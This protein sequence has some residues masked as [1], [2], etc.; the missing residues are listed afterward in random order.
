MQPLSAFFPRILTKVPGCA[1]P[2]AQQCL[3]DSA[4]EFC[5]ESLAVRSNLTPINTIADTQGYI[6]TD[7]ADEA[8]SRV[9]VVKIDGTEISPVDTISAA[10]VTINEKSKP[11]A[12]STV[13]EDGVLTLK[14]YPTPDKAYSV[15]VLAAMR[16]LRTATQLSDDL[17]NQWVDPVVNGTLAKIFST[18]MQPFTDPATAMAMGTL[19]KAGARKARIDSTTGSTQTTRSVRM[20]PFA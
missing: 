1:E 4:V 7:S 11:R 16:P 19:A 15:T 17:L 12:F 5:D 13:R 20:N 6:L 18:P 10:A 14:L 2:L 8:V 9:L 3:L